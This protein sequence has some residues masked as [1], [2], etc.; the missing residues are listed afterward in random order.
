MGLFALFTAL[1]FAACG[2]MTLPDHM[3]NVGVGVGTGLCPAACLSCF[4][5][6]HEEWQA[7][8]WPILFFSAIWGG[9]ASRSLFT[10]LE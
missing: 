1:A 10:Y 5:T 7:A 3:F 9:L 4:V 2:L 6:M 8:N